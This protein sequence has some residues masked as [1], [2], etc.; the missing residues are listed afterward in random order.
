MYLT[1]ILL[2]NTDGKLTEFGTEKYTSDVSYKDVEIKN[3]CVIS[4]T[5]NIKANNWIS[6]ENNNIRY[7]SDYRLEILKS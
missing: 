3:D 5:I 1:P 4:I 7:S 2:K 6:W